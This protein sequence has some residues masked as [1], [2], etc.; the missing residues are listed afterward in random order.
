MRGAKAP[1]RYGFCFF[2]AAAPPTTTRAVRQRPW[3]HEGL[4]R[5]PTWRMKPEGWE[6]RRFSS[7]SMVLRISSTLVGRVRRAGSRSTFRLNRSVTS[8]EISAV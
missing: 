2:P 3:R 4:T 5:P 1:L 6:N 7:V 8:L